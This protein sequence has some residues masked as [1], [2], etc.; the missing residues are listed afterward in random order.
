MPLPDKF[1]NGYVTDPCGAADAPADCAPKTSLPTESSCAALDCNYANFKSKASCPRSTNFEATEDEEITDSFQY[2]CCCGQELSNFPRWVEI[3]EGHANIT[4]IALWTA[5]V[6]KGY[7]FG[8]LFDE[9]ASVST[10]PLTIG[11]YGVDAYDMVSRAENEALQAEWTRRLTQELDANAVTCVEGCASQVVSGGTIMSWVDEW[12]KGH[13]NTN[14]CSEGGTTPGQPRCD[15]W[16]EG[17]TVIPCMANLNNAQCVRFWQGVGQDTFEPNS[18]PDWD[19]QYHSVCGTFVEYSQPDDWL[20]EEWWGIVGLE[21]CDSITPTSYY[22]QA[23]VKPRRIFFELKLMWALGAGCVV[24]DSNSAVASHHFAPPFDPVAYPGCGADVTAAGAAVTALIKDF[25]LFTRLPGVI[26]L[27][28]NNGVGA[29]AQ[30]LMESTGS[31]VARI[32]CKLKHTADVLDGSPQ[33]ADGDTKAADAVAAARLAFPNAACLRAL[34]QHY[35]DGLELIGC[36]LQAYAAC[37]TPGV[38]RRARAVLDDLGD[39]TTAVNGTDL[40][41][42]GSGGDGGAVEVTD[43]AEYVARQRGARPVVACPPFAP[44][45]NPPPMPAAPPSPPP[46]QK[47]RWGE[48]RMEVYGR[49]ILLDGEVWIMRGICYS[50]SPFGSDPG[51]GEPWGDYFTTQYVQI[52]ERDIKL[53]VEMGAN[54]IR[55]YTYKRSRRHSEFMDMAMSHN[56]AI[57]GA[58]EMGTAEHTPL[59]STADMNNAKVKLREQIR[60]SAHPA[61]MMYLVGNELNG[62]W[63]LFVC[64]DEYA[65]KVHAGS[66]IVHEYGGCMFG[67]DPVKLGLKLDELCEVAHEEG[68]LC[69]TPWAGVNLPK[70]YITWDDY[71]CTPCGGDFW[72]NFP[73]DAFPEGECGYDPGSCPALFGSLGWIAMLDPILVHVDFWAVNMYPGKNFAH[74]ELG[75]DVRRAEPVQLL[76]DVRPGVEPA[77]HRLRVWD[78]RVRRR[79]RPVGE[80]R[81]QP[82]RH[83]QARPR[84]AGGDSSWAPPR[85]RCRPSGSRPGRGPREVLDDV[86]RRAVQGAG[87][88]GRLADGVGGRDVE[89]TRDRCDGARLAQR[90][91]GPGVPRQEPVLPHAVRLPVGRAARPLRE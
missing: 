67:E 51:Y 62:G 41:D 69:S 1:G 87:G 81:P 60:A 44:P 31:A 43:V 8:S 48:S 9:Y 30:G 88:V 36:P 77:V 68:M 4:N 39:N 65:H 61:M 19:A 40:A 23:M 55:L 58:F 73:E 22:T 70:S 27:D 15:R 66:S 21:P 85:T 37:V 78:R 26:G 18:C 72:N 79:R 2:E 6:Y 89:G 82:G 11:E 86:R 14:T 83:G 5:N 57:V 52:F 50:P 71:L 84:P 47:R 7:T 80:H 54:T 46:P 45:P 28:A 29:C 74:D 10:R 25:G 53:M 63:Q 16:Y 64:E 34:A 35:L 90:A 12:Y 59:N 56:L 38:R 42:F 13:F 20:N 17:N 32:A 24:H 49:Q 75:G 33:P 76:R 91:D 3:I